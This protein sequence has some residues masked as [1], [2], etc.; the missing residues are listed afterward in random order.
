VEALLELHFAPATTI[1]SYGPIPG[2]MYERLKDI[3]PEAQD[4]ESSDIPFSLDLRVVR[5]RFSSP[6]GTRMFQVGNGI[7]SVNNVKYAHYE[8]FKAEAA[9]VVERAID[10]LGQ[11]VQTVLRYINKIPTD[12]RPSN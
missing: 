12:G 7:L 4:L 3:Y 11:P 9:H 8:G 5:H 2:Q 10:V 6:D 1:R